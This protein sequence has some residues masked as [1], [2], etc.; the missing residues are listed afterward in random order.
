[1]SDLVYIL[2]H[3]VCLYDVIANTCRGDFKTR[4]TMT[5]LAQQEE[6]K[7]NFAHVNMT[8]TKHVNKSVF[9]FSKKCITL[10]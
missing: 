6:K 2:H 8:N 9:I 5:S 3:A 10:H 1:M 4:F 7:N